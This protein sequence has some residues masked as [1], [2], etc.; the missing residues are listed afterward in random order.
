[1]SDPRTITAWL[2]RPALRRAAAAV[3][4]VAIFLLALWVLHRTLGRFDSAQVLAGAKAYDS[5]TLVAALLLALASYGALSGFDWLGLHHVGRS[6]PF[7]WTM[8]IS[9]VS[10]AVSHNAGFAVLTGGSIRFR[11]YSAFGL[12]LAEVGGVI[13]FAGLSFALGVVALASTALIA[14]A[15]RVAPLLRLPIGLV[16]GCGFA[17]AS[18]L[19]FYFA[20][21]AIAKRPLA[22]GKWRLATPSVALGL[23][24][25][26]IAA[27]D[28]ALVAGVLYLLLPLRETDVTYAAFIGI[29]VVATVAG[30]ISHVPGGLGVFEGALILL[31]PGIPTGAVLAALLIFRVF[32]N[33]L[34]LV[35]AAL[36]LAVFELV[37]RR[38]HQPD[39]EWAT[40]LGPALSALLV[41]SAGGVL[42][43]SG[44][45]SSPGR[46]PLWLLEPAH[47]LSGGVAAVLLVLSWG[48][49][50]RA[51]WSYRLAIPALGLGAVLALM[52]GPDWIVAAILACA[53]ALLSAAGPLFHQEENSDESGVPLGWLG[54]AGAVVAGAVWL[55]WHSDDGPLRLLSFA[56]E[57]GGARA[58]RANM[59]SALALVTAAWQR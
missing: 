42:L 10:H 35:L 17:G 57:D 50:R 5:G 29:Y 38:R 27:F 12:G 18:L 30:T 24:Q 15:A 22:I 46:L 47:L 31:L 26:T 51:D 33:L 48:L 55:T 37:Q 16:M 53:L 56:A 58:M 19:I 2:A 25:V 54:A 3:F 44:A 28:L 52:R 49:L 9:F 4:S 39:P 20:W 40:K 59:V 11:M 34:P 1:M 45:V 32:Y 23:G 6:V 43:L 8:L 36:V 7:G 41:F 21:A 14:E 13:T